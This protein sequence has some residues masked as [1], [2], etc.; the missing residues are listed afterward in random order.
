MVGADR[1]AAHLGGHAFEEA[2]A[3]NTGRIGGRAR[4]GGIGCGQHMRLGD[5][6][7][8][9]PIGRADPVRDQ[10]G[11]QTRQRI[12]RRFIGDEI[13]GL[14]G[15]RV[16]KAVAH[17]AGDAQ[18]QQNRALAAAHMVGGRCC[19]AR[20]LCRVGAI[21]LKDG[22][23]LE[24]CQILGNIAARRLEMRG[25]G[26]AVAVVFD[27]E[28][29]RQLLGCGDGQ[30]RP[31]TVG[32]NRTVAA[33]RHRD[34]CAVIV[35]PQFAGVIFQRLRPA[36]GRGELRADPA[37]HGQR[38]GTGSVR[39]IRGDADIAPVGI[40]ADPTHA[41]RQRVFRRHAD[42]QQHRARP[43]ID[44][45]RVM[46]TGQL[47]AQQD[48]R[49][50]MAACRK[51]VTLLALRDQHGFLM[52][53]QRPADQHQLGHAMPVGSDLPAFVLRQLLRDSHGFL[54]SWDQFSAAAT[55]GSF[56]GHHH[57]L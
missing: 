32:R 13:G 42:R 31:E 38:R 28:Q 39:E 54:R 27:I 57:L 48:L 33:Q 20:G 29:H 41:G 7:Q 30:R 23:A 8:R 24:G 17:Q 51:L 45:D 26:N 34:G 37:R 3:G 50:V 18:M 55:D 47:Q 6:F 49:Q 56:K 52:Q 43:V 25:H 35:R 12:A 1:L 9:G 19:Q 2:V 16:L 5:G 22:Q 15:L 36:D 14:V 4:L 44:A 11:A 10:M 46:P 40:A 53:V 21:A